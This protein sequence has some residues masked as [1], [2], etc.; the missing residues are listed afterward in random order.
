MCIRWPSLDNTMG[1]PTQLRQHVLYLFLREGVVAL[2]FPFFVLL[3]PSCR[4]RTSP[5]NTCRHSMHGSAT[6][7]LTMSRVTPGLTMCEVFENMTYDS[8]LLLVFGL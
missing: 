5:S 1:P 7:F 3:I 2:V 8:A 4:G 6:L